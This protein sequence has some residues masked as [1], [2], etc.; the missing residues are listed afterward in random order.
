MEQLELFKACLQ[1]SDWPCE[2]CTATRGSHGNRRISSV[3]SWL[4]AA[5]WAV[6]GSVVNTPL[7]PPFPVLPLSLPALWS[8]PAESHKGALWQCL[9]GGQ[10]SSCS[11]PK[12]PGGNPGI[13]LL[14]QSF[15]F[16]DSWQKELSN[17]PLSP[18]I[19]SWRKPDKLLF[20]SVSNLN[21]KII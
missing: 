18:E 13:L 6:C 12:H 17:F 4:A 14:R 1:N 10:S 21:E 9:V 3:L 16:H 7:F 5:G 19:P 15:I 20:V 2:S 11:Q 8:C